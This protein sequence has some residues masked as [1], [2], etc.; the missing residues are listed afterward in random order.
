MGDT[1]TV[2]VRLDESK[3]EKLNAICDKAG[4][5]RQELL[6]GFIDKVIENQEEIIEEVQ[7]VGDQVVE[8]VNSK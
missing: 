7:P 5:A 3:K 8:L 1:T 6:E 2:S 4:I